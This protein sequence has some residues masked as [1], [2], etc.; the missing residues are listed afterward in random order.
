MTVG[1]YS[2]SPPTLT[3]GHVSKLQLDSVGN[4]KIVSGGTGA[5]ANQVQG[6]TAHDA[7]YAGNPLLAGGYASATAPTSVADGDAVRAWHNRAGALMVQWGTPTGL[8]DTS[9]ATTDG[10]SPPNSLPVVSWGY[11]YNGTNWDRLRGD[12]ANGLVVQQ[13]GAE[14]ETVAASQTDQVLG[15]TGAAGDF[16]RGLLIIPATTSPGEVSIE[17]GATNMIVFAGGA[18]SLTELRPI[19]IPLGI[20]STSGGWEVSTGASVSVLAAGNFT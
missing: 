11:A 15:A 3:D 16:L 4:L 12:S 5:S 20:K 2:L 6:T 7:V 13:S 10:R 17:D 18:S 19:W 1:K 8:I 14:Y 9:S